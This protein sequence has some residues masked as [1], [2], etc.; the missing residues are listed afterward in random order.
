MTTIVNV[1]TD[2]WDVY[3]G[4][5]VPRFAASPWGNPYRVGKDGPPDAVLAKYAVWLTAR[6]CDPAFRAATLALRGKRLGCWCKPGPC[7]GDVLAIWI[8]A[9]AVEEASKTAR[10]ARGRPFY[11]D[12]CDGTGWIEGGAK[13]GSGPATCSRCAGSGVVEER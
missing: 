2:S 5:K 9:L 1:R 8:E 4:R 7:H 6:F 3:I 13:D 10:R 12:D 11:C